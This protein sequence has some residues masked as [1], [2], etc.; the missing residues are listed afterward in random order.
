MNTKPYYRCEDNDGRD[1]DE[2]YDMLYGPD[3]FKCLLTEPEDRNWWR[4]GKAVVDKLNEQ[5]E[6]IQKLREE[7][8]KYTS[9]Y[10]LDVNNPL[11]DGLCGGVDNSVLYATIRHLKSECDELKDKVEQ[12]IKEIEKLKKQDIFPGTIFPQPTITIHSDPPFIDTW[13]KQ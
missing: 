7:L 5:H 9:Q 3:G 1:W 8:K 10:M 6:E 11:F 2:Y 13:C 12:L 4:D